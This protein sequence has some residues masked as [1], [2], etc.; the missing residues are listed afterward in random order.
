MQQSMPQTTYVTAPQGATANN[1]QVQYV[2]VLPQQQ[3]SGNG[4]QVPQYVTAAPQY[5]AGMLPTMMVPFAMAG[6]GAMPPPPPPPPPAY[7]GGVFQASGDQT[8]HFGSIGSVAIL[9]PP[10]TSATI[11]A[12]GVTKGAPTPSSSIADEKHLENSDS[13]LQTSG[14]GT[15]NPKEFWAGGAVSNGTDAASN[16][17]Q[18]AS[19]GLGDPASEAMI[20]D[21]R[22]E[23][24]DRSVRT[25]VIRL[26]ASLC[27]G[28][29][30][31]LGSSEEVMN[32]LCMR[33]RGI[34]VAH[35]VERLGAEG[36]QPILQYASNR[37]MT[38]ALNQSGCIAL[39]RILATLQGPPL[40]A[41]FDLTM[42]HIPALIDHPFGNYVV[43][44][45]A[46]LK[47]SVIN[48]RLLNEYF[49]H[50]YVRIATN[51]YG[52]HVME[53]VLRSSTADEL[54]PFARVAFADVG[55]LR[56]LAHDRFANYCIQTMFRVLANGD[57]RFH[58]WCVGQMIG[59]VRGSPYEQ[60]I[61]KSAVAGYRGQQQ[62]QTLPP[63]PPGYP[64]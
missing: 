36:S 39:P 12:G 55:G 25:R 4:Q 42:Q 14:N 38:L 62:Q 17:G 33:E 45:F 58:S 27:A 16:L 30:N 9:P 20:A 1:Q 10:A 32:D 50:H 53:D 22:K 56:T 19:S 48:Q 5:G 49:V 2:Y 3:V 7:S 26:P 60:N 15:I 41:F 54:Y 35:L 23:K 13:H 52:S 59:A 11:E 51:K 44:H 31:F 43:K 47:D 6:G 46:G 40:Y 34:I 18:S 37:F 21:L 57:A 63:P 8:Q 29:V 28:M 64:A 61:M 24:T